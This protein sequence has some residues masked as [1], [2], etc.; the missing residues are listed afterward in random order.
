MSKIHPRFL[1]RD[2]R[3]FRQDAGHIFAC[4]CGCGG[5]VIV[6]MEQ[7]AK[8]IAQRVQAEAYYARAKL[9]RQDGE[10]PPTLLC[11]ESFYVEGHEPVG[12]HNTRTG[13]RV[14]LRATS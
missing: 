2:W 10:R 1:K 4:Q 5:H 7:V 12:I 14:A 6:P 3:G 8:S 11:G 9:K 13:R